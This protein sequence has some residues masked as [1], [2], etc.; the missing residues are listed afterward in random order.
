M[1]GNTL[2]VV[3]GPL[4]QHARLVAASSNFSLYM[5]GSLKFRGHQYAH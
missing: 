5:S 4:L 3:L 2:A 1:A